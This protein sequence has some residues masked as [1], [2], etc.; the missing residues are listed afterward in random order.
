MSMTPEDSASWRVSAYI[1]CYNNA[2]T[3][4]LAIE[5]MLKQSHPIDDFFVVDDG[6]TDASVALIESLGVRVVR[7]GE[8]KGRGT[9][10]ATAME[11]VQNEFV[12]CGDATNRLSPDFVKSGLKWFADDRVLAVYGRCYDRHART[13]I[14]RWRARHLYQQDIPEVPNPRGAF[15]TYGAIVRK[16]AIL[17]AGNYDRRLRHGEDFELG[18]RL[19]QRGDVVADPTLEIQPV[20]PNTLFQV[21]E[22]FA[23]W[24]RASIL[25]YDLGEFIESHILAWRILIPRDLA[26]GDV[27]GAL[28]SAMVPYFSFAYADKK[29]LKFSSKPPLE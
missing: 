17:Q 28:I 4:G 29:S 9:A 16:S 3:I 22:R 14:D 2:Q 7:L 25:T 10:R 20:V 18:V 15:S 11:A 23:R 13:T 5:G 21:M 26:H 27:P 24:N 8:N 19:L 1:P 12:L 6:S